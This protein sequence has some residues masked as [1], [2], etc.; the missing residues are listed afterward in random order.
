[1]LPRLVVVFEGAV[2]I[3]PDDQRKLYAKL[4]QK[5][6][7]WQAIDCYELNG[8]M[9]SKL[10]DLRWRLDINVNLVTWL[11]DEAAEA[12]QERM[13]DEGIPVGGCFAST[14]SRLTRELAYAPDIVAVY[15]PD[16]DHVF[17]YGSKG[18]VL[19]DANQIGRF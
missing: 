8:H 19:T 1:M 4:C 5:N 2:G 16:P 14:P 17:T 15:D 7:W 6:K 10:L 3:V 9:L 12:I 18:V 13:D 11:G